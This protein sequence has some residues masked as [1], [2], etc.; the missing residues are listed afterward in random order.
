MEKDSRKIKEFLDLFG[1][2]YTD[3]FSFDPF[4]NIF[5]IY[6]AGAAG[7]IL[8]KILILC[9]KDVYN[10]GRYGIGRFNA[11][12][13]DSVGSG[14]N[15]KTPI[16]EK[17][18]H[19]HSGKLHNFFNSKISKE[20]LFYLFSHARELKELKNVK[21]RYLTTRITYNNKL[22]DF[23]EFFPE[24]SSSDQNI[25]ITPDTYEDNVQRINQM[26]L[27]VGDTLRKDFSQDPE[28][29]WYT[30]NY[31]ELKNA[32]PLLVWAIAD[33][34]I[35][36]GF[37]GWW[38]IPENIPGKRIQYREVFDFDRVVTLYEDFDFDIDLARS[39]HTE[40][41]KRQTTKYTDCIKKALD[42]HEK[43]GTNKI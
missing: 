26:I 17:I 43:H 13:P 37:N 23:F 15:T 9:C 7:S 12:S 28:Y 3:Y 36:Q 32:D 31:S 21:G 8:A 11:S 2:E 38:K 6:K 35:D 20:E 1:L 22:Q 34:K 39:I 25:I 5:V 14:H 29:I 40:W 41:S 19:T 30:K 27:K 18:F 16:L 33:T 10:E 24:I 42:F 4:K